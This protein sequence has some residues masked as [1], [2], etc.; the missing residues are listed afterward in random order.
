[1]EEQ[2]YHNASLAVSMAVCRAGA[3]ESG[4]PLY[5]HIA[6]I[7]PHDGST[8]LFMP[9]PVVPVVSGGATAPNKLPFRHVQVACTAPR[10]ALPRAGAHSPPPPTLT[11]TLALA[12][13]PQVIASGCKSFTEAV[14]AGRAIQEA[15]QKLTSKHMWRPVRR[16]VDR[17]HAGCDDLCNA[18]PPRSARRRA[19]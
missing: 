11:L 2:L 3:R 5:R 1:M 18:A 16:A 15:A 4:I 10:H 8:N 13:A 12:A 7:G 6:Q 17:Q 14:E 9:V 19:T